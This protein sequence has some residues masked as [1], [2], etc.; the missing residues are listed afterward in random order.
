MFQGRLS[1]LILVLV[2]ATHAISVH[3]ADSCNLPQ[4]A[5]QKQDA[6][7]VAGLENSWSA[8]FLTGDTQFMR[9]LL[10]PEYTEITRSGQVKFRAYELAITEA[11]QGKGL[12]IP[13]L[14]KVNVM[15][16]G[17]IAVAYGESRTPGSDG[18]AIAR[19]SADSFVWE[20]GRWHAFFSQQTTVVQP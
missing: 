16:H 12:A 18:K 2:M 6:A 4:L 15:L 7:T 13:D 3:A 19:M 5:H 8:A 9:C 20:D 14:P 1:W 11:N 17:N 10:I